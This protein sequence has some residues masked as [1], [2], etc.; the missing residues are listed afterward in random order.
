MCKNEC[1]GGRRDT[2]KLKPHG[3]FPAQKQ[4][5][6]PN[7]T[8]HVGGG[9]SDSTWIRNS[10]APRW[11][12]WDKSAFVNF[13]PMDGKEEYCH[14]VWVMELRL[15]GWALSFLSNSSKTKITWQEVYYVP[16]FKVNIT[17]TVETLLKGTN[18][19][20]DGDVC[21]FTRRYLVQ[22]R[23]VMQIWLVI[24]K[25]DSIPAIGSTDNNKIW[26]HHYKHLSERTL[27]MT[28]KHICGLV[29]NPTKM[30]TCHNYIATKITC[31][32]FPKIN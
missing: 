6:I 18:K 22:N 7:Y 32:P 19:Q 13:K 9:S 1:N 12:M 11:Y 16:T 24:E 14:G 31:R 17:L 10:G 28:Q 4:E 8:F 29:L 27:N 15:R 21:C 26:H 30:D 2:G 3:I 25:S 5:V 20:V 23:W